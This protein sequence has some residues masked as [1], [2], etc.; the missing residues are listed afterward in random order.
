MPAVR[1]HQGRPRAVQHHLIDEVLRLL[2]AAG[3]GIGLRQHGQVVA[4]RM[5]QQRSH[6]VGFV[7]DGFKRAQ[8]GLPAR[9]VELTRRL[10]GF[11]AEN[12]PGLGR[13]FGQRDG[14]SR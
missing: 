5:A 8:T 11:G 9:C 2:V 7:D 6:L 14:R 3:T 13:E 10:V 4:R 1:Q 12:V